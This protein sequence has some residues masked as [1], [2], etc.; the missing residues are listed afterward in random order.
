M[1]TDYVNEVNIIEEKNNLDEITSK[2]E[3]SREIRYFSRCNKTN[4]FYVMDGYIYLNGENISN[5]K[6]SFYDR[7]RNGKIGFVFQ[8]LIERAVKS[9]RH[10]V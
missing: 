4:S 3:S 2:I 7:Y 1:F 9:L 6:S 10:E 5:K 8:V